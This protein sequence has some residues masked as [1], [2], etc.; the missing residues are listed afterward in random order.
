MAGDQ[1]S[2]LFGQACFGSGDAK[3]TYGTGAFILMNTQERARFRARMVSLTTVGWRLNGE[4][5]YAARGERL[6]RGGCGAVAPRS[7]GII[8]TAEEIEALAA[9]VPDSGGGLCARTGRSGCAPLASD[10]RGTF[11]GITGYTTKAHIARA[12]L[13]GIAL[14]IADILGAMEA[15]AD[16]GSAASESTAAPPATTCH[17]VPGGHFAPRRSVR[18]SSRPRLWAR[19]PRRTCSWLLG[20]HRILCA[21]HG[22][23]D[24]LPRYEG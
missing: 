16:S 8:D 15:D 12:V 1:Q 19:I 9:S 20:N 5:T 21:R 11:T 22:R 4:T 3:C 18:P 17:A 10:A 2:A 6:H 23:R 7:M 14:Q 24:I 13:E